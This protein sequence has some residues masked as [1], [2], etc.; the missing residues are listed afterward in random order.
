MNV[1]H[2]IIGPFLIEEPDKKGRMVHTTMNGQRYRK[3]LE[4]FFFPKIIELT[5]DTF[6]LQIFQQ[7]GASCHWAGP[8]L[9]LLETYFLGRI[10]SLKHNFPWPPSSPDLNVCDFYLWPNTKNVSLSEFLRCHFYL[11]CL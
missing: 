9:D 11:L 4:E 3:M 7:D 6:H 1:I 2:G 8:T 5:G 10:I